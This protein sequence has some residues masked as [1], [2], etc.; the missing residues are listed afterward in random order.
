MKHRSVKLELLLALLPLV[1]AGSVLHEV[2]NKAV[3][4]V[5]VE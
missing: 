4:V 5:N 3:K 1:I 2:H